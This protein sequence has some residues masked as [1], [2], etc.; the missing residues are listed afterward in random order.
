MLK[1]SLI[2]GTCIVL[3]VTSIYIAGSII[4]D[5]AMDDPAIAVTISID[6]PLAREYNGQAFSLPVSFK[7]TNNNKTVNLNANQYEVKM[8]EEDTA[9]SAA[10]VDTGSYSFTVNITDKKYT[11]SKSGSFQITKKPLEIV[12]ENTVVEYG[13]ENTFTYK[14]LNNSEKVTDIEHEILYNG[15]KVVPEEPGIY[16][17]AV[18]IN[19]NVRNFSGSKTGTLTLL[20]ADGDFI[21]DRPLTISYSGEAYELGILGG[22]SL[23]LQDLVITYKLKDSAD[24]PTQTIPT[25]AGIYDVSASFSVDVEG[26]PVEYLLESILTITKLNIGLLTLAAPDM[27]INPSPSNIEAILAGGG[28]EQQVTPPTLP[29]FI[30]VYDMTVKD[31]FGATMAGNKIVYGGP[32][33]IIIDAGDSHNNYFGIAEIPFDATL[34][35]DDP[36]WAFLYGEYY[37]EN[38]AAHYESK[39]ED[40]K[41][42]PSMG[43]TQATS[44][45]KRRSTITDNFLCQSI[46]S[47]EI[48]DIKLFG[49]YNDPNEAMQVHVDSDGVS[50]RHVTGKPNVVDRYT[51]VF[52]MVSWTD[53]TK[54]DFKT[55]YIDYPENFTM[56]RI[57]SDTINASH[58]DT[59]FV[60]GI[61]GERVLHLAFTNLANVGVDYRARIL[62]NLGSG[63]TFDKFNSLKPEYTID[64]YGRIIKTVASEQYSV[65]Q[66]VITVTINLSSTERIDYTWNKAI[67]KNLPIVF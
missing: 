7:E 53:T 3:G 23:V 49:I 57:D 16:Q 65:K 67:D 47:G 24:E 52:D 42:Q 25:D 39:M 46:T 28:E 66:S 15:L 37:F 43:G 12:F 22:G 34:T 14:I 51:P 19:E 61:D 40:G 44:K 21:F 30:D 45:I 62:K 5:N 60:P 18:T 63:Q 29:S 56:L 59:K 58:A 10:P 17:V 35:I 64:K 27:V 9:I 1:K 13:S 32:Y 6:T 33:T 54:A 11:G 36:V 8:Y 41:V 20:P 4:L 50:F 38:I 2:I 55:D 48:I 26:E 31:C